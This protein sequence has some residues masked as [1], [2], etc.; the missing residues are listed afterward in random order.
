MDVTGVV[1]A[2][3]RAT[4]MGGRDKGLIPL[5]GQPLFEH[6]VSKL[7]PQVG[8]IAIA[9]NR[10]IEKYQSVGFTVLRD[11]LADFPGPLAG[12]LSAMQ[13]LKGE[14]F[15]FCPCD[16]PNIP[17]DLAYK[18]WMQKGDSSAVWVNDGERDHPTI[19]LVHRRLI[20]ELEQYLDTGERRV[21]VFLRQAGGKAIVF[22]NQTGRFA[23]INTPEDLA[24]WEKE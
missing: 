16:T 17:G 5:N 14:W 24:Q 23:N 6:I 13:Q 4:R 9:A 21:M 10:N 11:T 22:E 2:G 12:M 18:L 15:L 7:I 1:L 3:G 20:K 19:A 8:D